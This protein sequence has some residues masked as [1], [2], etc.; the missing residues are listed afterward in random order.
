VAAGL[1]VASARSDWHRSRHLLPRRCE[2][3][4]SAR[5]RKK[6]S[7]APCLLSLGF[8]GITH[9]YGL[10]CLVLLFATPSPA[11]RGRLPAPITITAFARDFSPPSSIFDSPSG[12]PMTKLRCR[13]PSGTP[14]GRFIRLD[15]TL[16]LM[17]VQGWCSPSSSSACSSGTFA[18]RWKERESY[19][20]TRSLRGK[21]KLAQV[22]RAGKLIQ[23][24]LKEARQK[25][26]PIDPRRSEQ[27]MDRLYPQCPGLCPSRGQR[28][29]EETATKEIDRERK[30][31]WNH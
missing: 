5:S 2:G 26:S 21:Q 31:R 12:F 18:E 24:Q 10:G 20:S 14:E 25:F 29:Q 23:G 22:D 27:E 15:A 9:H 3:I 11:D 6:R 7:A 19:L 1:A 4:P 28:Q 8:I 16:P 17:A 30:L 13:A